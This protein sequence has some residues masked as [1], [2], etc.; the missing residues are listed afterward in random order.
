M[1]GSLVAAEEV[2]SGLV[3]RLNMEDVLVLD[4][5]V[6]TPLVAFVVVVC[7]CIDGTVRDDNAD[8]EEDAL[9]AF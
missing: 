8:A 3:I 4:V 2:T 5:S 1:L 7:C 9:L 6:G